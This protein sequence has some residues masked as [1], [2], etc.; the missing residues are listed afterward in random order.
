MRFLLFQ[1]KILTE[2]YADSP[3]RKRVEALA[4][5]GDIDEFTTALH[6][7]F[8]TY[9]HVSLS[10]LTCICTRVSKAMVRRILWI[11]C[12]HVA[13]GYRGTCDDSLMFE[14][15]VFGSTHAEN[16]PPTKIKELQH[17][18]QRVYEHSLFER[19]K[20][21]RKHDSRCRRYDGSIFLDED[22]SENDLVRLGDWGKLFPRD[23]SAEK[24]LAQF[25]EK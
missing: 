5:N 20:H 10:G 13:G 25:Y 2:M 16:L 17:W 6:K 9:S 15:L 18:G 8:D 22:W 4:A 7:M 21:R 3:E 24:V 12:T 1:H 19:E 23:E 14:A 11:V